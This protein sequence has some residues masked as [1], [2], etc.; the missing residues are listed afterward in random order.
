MVR[1][2]ESLPDH[3]RVPVAVYHRDPLLHMGLLAS[4]RDVRGLDVSAVDAMDGMARWSATLCDDRVAVCDYETGVA[5]AADMGRRRG[6]PRVMVVTQRD[7]ETDVQTA[8]ARGVRGYLLVGCGVQDV[9]DAVIALS[10]GRR[11][12]SPSAA[13]RVADGIYYEALTP[14]EEEVLRFL[15]IGWSNKRVATRMGVSEG[16]VKCHVKAIFGKLAVSTRTEA[17]TVAIRRGLASPD[18]VAVAA[19]ASAAEAVGHSGRAIAFHP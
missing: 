7:G 13:Q 19:V 3:G 2:A 1:T 11:F 18:A 14:R 16:T 8:L 6:A 5:L 10:R 15:V 4:L 17:A 12:L 9:V